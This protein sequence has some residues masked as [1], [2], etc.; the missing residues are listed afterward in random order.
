MTEQT[1][2]S[3]QDAHPPRP[4]GG[5]GKAARVLG[6]VSLIPA[7]GVV[8][9]PVG[10]VLAVRALAGGRAG[11]GRALAAV[12]LCAAGLAVSLGAVPPVLRWHWQ[13]QREACAA[14]LGYVAAGIGM[15]RDYSKRFPAA[16]G[17]VA[18]MG[19]VAGI[20]L[21]CPGAGRSSRGSDY[22]YRP[23]ADDAPAEAIMACDFRG[24]H[25]GGRNVLCRDGSVGWQSEAA[26][27]AELAEPYN[28][29]FA[30]ALREAEGP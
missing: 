27:Q 8:A 24:N 17:D 15:Y 23:P 10:L 14:R 19:A 4:G 6:I 20:Y 25:R 2:E 22:F 26:F 18:A 29:E 12:V 1:K 7:V 9:A 5:L 28:A 3:R 30:K 13:R 16:L 21:S 11:R